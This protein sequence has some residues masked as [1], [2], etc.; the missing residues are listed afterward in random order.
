MSSNAPLTPPPT[1][2]FAR[3]LGTVILLIAGIVLL[4]PGVCALG[5]IVSSSPEDFTDSTIVVLWVICF[6]I[7]FGGAALIWNAVKFWRSR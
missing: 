1:S 7:A 6:A 5:F 3:G 4:L 2:S